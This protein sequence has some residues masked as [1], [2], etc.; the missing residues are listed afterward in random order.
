MAGT[1]VKN[2]GSS[3]EADGTK[4]RFAE[5]LSDKYFPKVLTKYISWHIMNI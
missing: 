1:N 2:R 3:S 5:R 4:K